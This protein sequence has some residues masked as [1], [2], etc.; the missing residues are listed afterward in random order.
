MELQKTLSIIKPDAMEL[1]YSGK[2]IDFIEENP[3]PL[4]L[5]LILIENDAFCP[6]Y[7]SIPS[8]LGTSTLIVVVVIPSLPTLVLVTRVTK[9]GELIEIS[10][11]L[12]TERVTVPPATPTKDTNGSTVSVGGT[13]ILSS[14]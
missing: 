5:L 12:L 6:A 8:C 7:S 10:D 11:E 3:G 4:S 1:K 2:I 9:E 13:L 14:V